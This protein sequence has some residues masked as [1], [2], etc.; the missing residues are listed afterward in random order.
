MSDDLNEELLA[1]LDGE[2]GLGEE[3]LAP[4]ELVADERGRVRVVYADGSYYF[5]ELTIP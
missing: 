4:V 1:L 5:S 2:A 3:A